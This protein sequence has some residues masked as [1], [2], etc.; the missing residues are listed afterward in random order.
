MSAPLYVRFRSPI[1]NARGVQV[2]VF[3]LANGLAGAGKLNE[4]E[5]ARW[6]RSNDWFEVAYAEPT[7]THPAV[8]DRTVNPG[9]VAWFK[10]SAVE[11]IEKTMVYTQLLDA[12][13]VAWER[14]ET[15]FPG[16]ILYEDDIQFI[17]TCEA[18]G[19]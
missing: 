16:R 17:A 9:A 10:I 1:P 13:R 2:G 14:V 12:H 11:L 7:R 18:N 15:S 6:R 3:A 4:D 5:H 8:Y 19:G